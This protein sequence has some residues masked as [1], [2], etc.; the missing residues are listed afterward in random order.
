MELARSGAEAVGFV[1][2][3]GG[4]HTPTPDDAKKIQGKILVLHGAD[5]P[6]VP[7]DEVLAFEEEMRSA[8]AD[9][10][11]FAYG[12]AV[13]GFTVPGAGNDPSTGVAYN[14]KTDRR[15]WEAMKVFFNEIF[16]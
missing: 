3:H 16:A 2:F 9:W 14:E 1:S 6:L 11:L 5:D 15:S 12:N 7:S 10:Q 13:H 4:L 8:R